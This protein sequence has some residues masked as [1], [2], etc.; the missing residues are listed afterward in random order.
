M[1]IPDHETAPV[2][3]SSRPLWSP[4]SGRGTMTD[5]E[6]YTA[7]Q[8]HILQPPRPFQHHQNRVWDFLIARLE[9]AM[10]GPT[11]EHCLGTC[12]TTQ[13]SPTLE[14]QGFI[15]LKKGDRLANFGRQ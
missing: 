13:N 4:E 9:P 11:E 7:A 1:M 10:M 8:R 14:W 2:R 12:S 3:C 5:T 6:E 15:K